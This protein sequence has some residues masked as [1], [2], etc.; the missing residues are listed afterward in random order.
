MSVY[1][2]YYASGTVITGSLDM[3]KPTGFVQFFVP[4]ISAA[5]ASAFRL[6]E[7]HLT[8][9]AC[10]YV[11]LYGY[12]YDSALTAG[13]SLKGMPFT[14]DEAVTGALF[15]GYLSSASAATGYNF[16]LVKEVSAAEP[17]AEGTYTLSGIK[18]IEAGTSMTFP[19]YGSAAWGT[20]S[21]FVNMGFGDILWAT[22]NLKDDGSIVSPLESGDYYQWGAT[23]PCGESGDGAYNDNAELPT[24]NDVA[25]LRSSGEWRMPSRAQFEALYNATNTSNSWETIGSTTLGRLF[26][27]KVNGVSVFFAA[28]GEYLSGSTD[29]VG[30]Y[31]RYWSTTPISGGLAN[32]LIFNSGYVGMNDDYRTLG[33]SIRPVTAVPSTPRAAMDAVAGDLGKVIGQNGYIYDS[34]TDATAAGTTAVAVITYV[35]SETGESSPYNHGLAL[36]M[37]DA[38]YTNDNYPWWS[39]SEGANRHSYQVTSDNFTVAESGLQYNSTQNTSAFPAF[40]AAI[41]NNGVS[42]P[43]GC[44]AW[45]L[46]SGYQWNTMLTA[47]GSYTALSNCFSSIG[48]TQLLMSYWTSTERDQD[49]AWC[50]RAFDGSLVGNIQKTANEK[51]VRSCV[52][53]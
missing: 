31:G 8:P 37:S 21:P 40:K 43:V 51:R 47:M 29:H 1:T 34:A 23:A 28:A 49:R 52:A 42:A 20:M 14:S 15:G 24:A 46:S 5:D 41:S 35:G 33:N 3:E 16:S 10:D 17:A 32:Y 7:S 18:T 25:Y 22:G 4:G 12:V 2:A 6:M 26:T 36:A 13:Y 38:N 48:G 19:T 45:F 39:L 50:Y 9:K 27:S 53:F 11:S 30:E 44:S